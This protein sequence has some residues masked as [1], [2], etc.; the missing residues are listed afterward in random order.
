MDK[1]KKLTLMSGITNIIIGISI[2]IPF[3]FVI[4]QYCHD[5]TTPYISVALAMVVVVVVII[6][7]SII[8]VVLLIL[9]TI[10]A[11]LYIKLSRSPNIEY[12]SLKKICIF[13][14]ILNVLSFLFAIYLTFIW[15]EVIIID[16]FIA[17]STILII[18][19]HKICHKTSQLQDK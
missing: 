11:T 12:L 5:K 9:H 2:L 13:N 14:Y 16:I 6:I 10:C 1:I 15:L 4:Y 8:A 19:N 3:V 17:L 7:L 18:I